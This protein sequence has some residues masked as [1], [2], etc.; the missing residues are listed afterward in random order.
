MFSRTEEAIVLEDDCLPH[1]DF[2]PFCAAMLRHFR[3]EVRVMMVTGT[4]FA[5]RWRD[6]EQDFHFSHYGSIWGWATW[7]RAWKYYDV[8][9]ARWAEPGAKEAIRQLFPAD[10]ARVR[11][12]VFDAVATGRVDTWDFQWTLARL[13]QSGLTI[14][15]SRNLVRNVGFGVGATHTSSWSRHAALE[16]NAHPPPYRMSATVVADRAYDRFLFANG[17]CGGGRRGF[18]RMAAEVGHVVRLETAR[19]RNLFSEDWKSW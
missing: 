15:P 14:V 12:D 8:K 13:L 4:N 16:L 10:E 6:D 17:G 5:G 2:F 3:D 7:R 11:E 1:P 18:W 9:A 19:L